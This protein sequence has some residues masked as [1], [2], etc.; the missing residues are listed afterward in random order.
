MYFEVR[1]NKNFV[2][3]L[4]ISSGTGWRNINNEADV[5]P[6]HNGNRGYKINNLTDDST[7][8]NLLN[9][10][11]DKILELKKDGFIPNEYEINSVDSTEG[12]MD[13]L[14]PYLTSEHLIST[15]FNQT[16]RSPDGRIYV[17]VRLEKVTDKQ[18]RKGGRKSRKRKSRTCKSFKYNSTILVKRPVRRP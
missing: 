1:H 18:V 9:E 14:F 16:S 6:L 3:R 17:D 8:Q 10:L 2:M 12:F 5:E 13:E 7:G 4:F 11:N 15:I